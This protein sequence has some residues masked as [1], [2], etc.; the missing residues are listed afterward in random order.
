[1][2]P[3]KKNSSRRSFIKTGIAA[4][5]IMIV[6]RNVLGGKG[7]I[8]PSDQLN[9]AAIGSGGK[10]ASDISNASVR[11]RERVVA[12]CDVDFSG[13]ASSTVKKFPK[14]KLYDDYRR[15]L[16]K[17][18]NIDAVTISTPDHVH[19]P[20]ATYA[21]LRG[22]HV[23]VQKPMTHNIREA[24]ILTEMA[25]KQKVVTQMG[26]QGGS[27]PLLNMVQDWIDK[28]KLGAISEVKIWTNRPVWPS[29]ISMPKPDISKKPSAL[30]WD[31]WLG[32]AKLKPYTPNMH[33]FNW[34]GWWDYG[35]GAL[36]DVGCHLIDIPFR[37]LGLKYPKAAECSIG[38]VFSK[39]WSPDFNPESCPP[40]S[41]IT[42]NFDAT[43]KSKSPIVMT[44]SDGGIRPS[45]PS[46]IPANSDIG[47]K[48]SANGV[49]IIGE[50]GVISTNI[51]DS[52]PLMPKLY[53]NDG[54]TDFGPEVEKMTEPEYGHQRKWVDA[55]KAGFNSKEHL[56]LTS[57][58][59]YAGP[60]TETVLMGNLAIRSYMLRDEST[61]E[62]LARKKL[63]WDGDNMKIT[64]LEAAN[65]FVTRG[66]R[67][68]FTV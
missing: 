44:W 35:T 68:G 38:S 41:F 23:Y 15:M 61:K 10:G 2:K 21:M 60:M 65:Q 51:N 55:C 4:S 27:N 33:P 52:E 63:L 11:G 53:L 29:G 45:H 58:F 16:D 24:R 32:P 6:P 14:A 17:Q 43:S 46:V 28:G 40:S 22:K 20:A 66:Y 7:Y 48:N 49:L 37:T 19:A 67:A 57:S 12:L 39:M 5:S 62:F 31:L 42:I 26:N 9:I 47:G 64:N 1:M 8:S 59:D 36:G 13:S 50:K 54:T 30:N 56:A 3:K 18:K 25:R 34:R